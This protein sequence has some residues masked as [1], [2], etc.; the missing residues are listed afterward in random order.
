MENLSSNGEITY[1]VA[2]EREVNILHQLGYYDQQCRFFCHLVDNSDWMKAVIVHHLRLRSTDACHITEIEDWLR[3]SF[4]LCVPINIDNWKGR[5]Q[6]GYP[7]HS[8]IPLPYRVGEGFRTGNGDERI[9]CEAGALCVASVELSRCADSMIVRL[10]YVDRRNCTR[11][12]AL[13]GKNAQ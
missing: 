2:K 13:S 12:C 4:N 3:G 9:Q 6:P 8:P 10:C 7:C 5:Q 1:S 11:L